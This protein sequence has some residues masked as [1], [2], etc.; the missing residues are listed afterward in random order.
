M[1]SKLLKNNGLDNIIS[2]IEHN[3]R[4]KTQQLKV[5]DEVEDILKK[6]N[7]NPSI[8]YSA[9]QVHEDN[10][11]YCNGTNGEKFVY[12]NIFMNTDGL[13]TDKKDVALLIKFA[14]CTPIVL[15]DPVNQV[16]AIVHSGWRST[17][18][19]ISKSAI[20]KMVKD[21]KCKKENILAYV[22]PTIDIEN[23]EVGSE[24][25][26]AF[27][28]FKCRDEFFVKHKDKYKLSM[29][30]ANINILLEEGIL[31]NN[32]EVCEES[33]F[34]NSDLHSARRDGKNYGLNSMITIMK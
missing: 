30:D 23:Y 32:I 5:K 3:V 25:Y 28:D 34:K 26:D 10:V 21:F 4:Y 1:Y 6:S 16:Q 17:V 14:D 31:I 11:E 19:R 7:I 24:V 18:K 20:D 33:T 12:G 29:K 27:K 9:N 15:Y 22:G 8:I 13:I 2:G